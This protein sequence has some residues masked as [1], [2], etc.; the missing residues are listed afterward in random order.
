MQLRWLWWPRISALDRNL[1]IGLRTETPP[2]SQLSENPLGRVIRVIQQGL[3]GPHK[4]SKRVSRTVD[5]D[6]HR[7]IRALSPNSGSHRGLGV[8]RGHR[9]SIHSQP[10]LSSPLGVILV[11]LAGLGVSSSPDHR[12]YR[13]RLVDRVI[14]VVAWATLRGSVLRV[15]Q[16]VVSGEPLQSLQ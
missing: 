11:V 12:G 3:Q 10:G 7:V 13:F 6:H 5:R 8:T 15:P 9:P 16:Q 14:L 4:H 2:S 1:G